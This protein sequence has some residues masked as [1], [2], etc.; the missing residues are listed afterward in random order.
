M[1]HENLFDILYLQRLLICPTNYNYSKAEKKEMSVMIPNIP[2]NDDDFIYENL[3][4]SNSVSM[5]F[6]CVNN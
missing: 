5:K 1:T 3:V 4:D 2:G 6:N